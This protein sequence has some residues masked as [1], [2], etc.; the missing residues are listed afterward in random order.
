M[1]DTEQLITDPCRAEDTFSGPRFVAFA[2]LFVVMLGG[3]G[4]L[5][6]MLGH[7]SY[8]VQL[9]SSVSYSAAVMLYGFA[10]NKSGI[11]PY[12]FTCPTVVSQYPRLLKRHVGFL[13]VL[14]LF[15]TIALKFKPHLSAWWNTSSGKGMPPFFIAMA[16]PCC[17]LALTEIMTNRAVLERVHEDRFGEQSV[18]DGPEKDATISIFGRD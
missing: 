7:T 16:L 1:N 12:L 17:V 14:I 4:I 5:F 11:E 2:L 9:A 8:G 15:E 13:T 6:I 10:R 3:A 18:K